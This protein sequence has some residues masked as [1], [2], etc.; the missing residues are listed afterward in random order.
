M[1]GGSVLPCAAIRIGNGPLVSTGRNIC[2]ICALQAIAGIRI[3]SPMN[4]AYVQFGIGMVWGV[5]IGASL[6][7]AMGN[8]AMGIVMGVAI[9]ASIAGIL[10][11]ASDE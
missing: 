3:K 2:A 10:L 5:A 1:A 8:V 6:G 11:A 7:L 4:D 9:G